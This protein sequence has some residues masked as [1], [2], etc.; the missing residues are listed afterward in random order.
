ML[1]A[2]DRDEFD[3]RISVRRLLKSGSHSLPDAK[4]LK[5]IAKNLIVGYFADNVG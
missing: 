4:I 3:Q 1:P 5:N 2:V